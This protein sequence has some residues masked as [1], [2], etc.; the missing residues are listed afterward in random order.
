MRS[1][2]VICCCA[3]VSVLPGRDNLQTGDLAN[4]AHA[5]TYY[6]A[7]EAGNPRWAVPDF[8]ATSKLEDYS[9]QNEYR[10]VFSLTDALSFQNV[11]VKLVPD[12][13]PPPPKATR[14][15][16]H[17]VKVGSQRDICVLHEF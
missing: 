10:L 2:A 1:L 16:S 14:H 4:L 7:T 8:I 13:A 11:S 15:A 17:L 6:P 12:G 3:L 5:V 9:W